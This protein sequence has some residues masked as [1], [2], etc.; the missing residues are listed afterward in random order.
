MKTEEIRKLAEER[1]GDDMHMWAKQRD[2]FCEGFKQCIEYANNWIKCTDKM[3]KKHKLVFAFGINHYQKDRIVR[4]YYVS[5][6]SMSAEYAEYDGDCD[7]NK[8]EDEYFWP[9]GWYECN[10][11]EEINY[12]VPFEITH[13]KPMPRSPIK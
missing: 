11:V 3:P 4:A 10:E 12:K 8:D 7:Y 1:Y 5:K 6:Y 13:W 9:A 2:G